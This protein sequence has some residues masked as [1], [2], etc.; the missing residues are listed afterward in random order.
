MGNQDTTSRSR[1][2]NARRP[3][4]GFRLEDYAQL[5]ELHFWLDLTGDTIT[6][7]MRRAWMN[8]V[9]RLRS[10]YGLERDET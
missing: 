5:E 8:E 10:L 2:Q 6:S 4:I 9:Q 3:F 1:L 7:S